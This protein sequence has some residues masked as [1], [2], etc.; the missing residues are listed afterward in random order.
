M[1]EL[2]RALGLFLFI[3]MLKLVEYLSCQ[4]NKREEKEKRKEEK[5][6]IS[7]DKKRKEKK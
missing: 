4:K 7:R 1:L 6:R 5:K 2:S 3:V